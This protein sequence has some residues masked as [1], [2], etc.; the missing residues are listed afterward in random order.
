MD[1]QVAGM[2]VP[3]HAVSAPQPAVVLDSDRQS[4]TGLHVSII[5]ERIKVD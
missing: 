1:E 5:V 3:C 4:S 2:Q